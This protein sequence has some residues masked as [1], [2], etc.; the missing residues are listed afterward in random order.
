MRR[1]FFILNLSL[2]LFAEP[3]AQTNFGVAQIDP[4]SLPKYQN[5]IDATNLAVM[6]TLKDITVGE[7]GKPNVYV[8]PSRDI[9]IA[10][11]SVKFR[12][13]QT[14]N[15]ILGQ[16]N[17]VQEISIPIDACL[18]PTLQS[19][20][21]ETANNLHNIDG[22]LNEFYDSLPEIDKRISEELKDGVTVSAQYADTFTMF[23]NGKDA[24]KSIDGIKKNTKISGGFAEKIPFL[25]SF[26]NK[27]QG[28]YADIQTTAVLIIILG[29]LYF[30]STRWAFDEI[31]WGDSKQLGKLA[32]QFG[33]GALIVFF[34]LGAQYKNDAVYT[35]AHGYW[36]MLVQK[37]N[38]Y[39]SAI[40]GFAQYE[41]IRV[42]V[43]TS[44]AA[45]FR[46]KVQKATEENLKFA[47]QSQAHA[48][49][50][51]GCAE[52][53]DIIGLKT[54]QNQKSGGRIFPASYADA[55]SVN[56]YDFNARFLKQTNT[57]TVAPTPY[58]SLSTCSQ[59]E[60]A[61][62]DI[63]K[64]KT[65]N[66]A[67]I[68]AARNVSLRPII[69]NSKNM[70]KVSHEQGWTGIA[71]LP[72][73]RAMSRG[74]SDIQKNLD[75]SA[76][77][78]V[79]LSGHQTGHS[80]DFKGL[81]EQM[82]NFDL[83]QTADSLGGRMAFMIVPGAAQWYQTVKDNG[84]AVIDLMALPIELPLIAGGKAAE[85]AGVVGQIVSGGGV[86]TA[87]VSATSA[88]A[89]KT[90]DVGKNI[91]SSFIA[92]YA[93]T[94]IA[95]AAVENLI[96]LV[97][98]GVAGLVIAFYHFEVLLYTLAIPFA[99]VFAFSKDQRIK[100]LQFLI[101]GVAIAVKPI[102]IVISVMAAVYIA[103]LFH[104][105]TYQ[106]IESQNNMLVAQASSVYEKTEWSWSNPLAGLATMVASTI[107]NAII[108]G[109][110]LII[111]A[112]LEVYLIAKII[113]SGPSM[114]WGFFNVHGVSAEQ[115]AE[116]VTGQVKNY[117]Q[118]I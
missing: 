109:I 93:A 12:I 96:Y 52:Q 26:F 32:I 68:A 20:K 8:D 103:D 116:G 1:L 94:E 35:H 75:K 91:A 83:Q 70:L 117:E 81:V 22:Q 114:F 19:V 16:K 97:I 56:E 2:A 57:G 108:H 36:S 33:G 39:A 73:N 50:L 78:N 17:T 4:V 59:S 48:K 15:E 23:T 40:A 84:R 42:G 113:I 13:L 87:A 99:A 30:L 115:M 90:I 71:L 77:D 63:A 31:N 79:Q 38:T 45:E 72:A 104:S 76:M 21:T 25:G 3:T 55:G 110:L 74:T 61:Y 66:E 44:G 27:I 111:A 89:L 53:Y 18:K 60:M 58:Y 80:F 51:L 102:L 118:S 95:K 43:K 24:N 64:L 37:G 92:Y 112:V 14:G 67:V 5:C 88:V 54:A 6:P 100:V 107:K 7:D 82:K 10:N 29:A 62:R 9:D 106:L 98:I 65:A 85:N 69:E 47:V 49:I 105:I 11:G 41:E 101:K 46:D 28:V 86:G 34:F